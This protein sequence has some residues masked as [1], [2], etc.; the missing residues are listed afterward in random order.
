MEL[1]RTSS[2][3]TSVHRYELDKDSTSIWK[4]P[5]TNLF[6]RPILF[7]N[8]MTSGGLYSLIYVPSFDSRL[9]DC[10]VQQLSGT[11]LYDNELELFTR[12]ELEV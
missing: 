8:V 7:F 2:V 6:L 1:N 9:L 12:M 4:L 5:L 11:T 3:P 10:E